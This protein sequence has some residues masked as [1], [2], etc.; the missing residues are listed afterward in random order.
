MQQS[1]KKIFLL[2]GFVSQ[3]NWTSHVP[4][5]TEVFDHQ[6]FQTGPFILMV[7]L[8]TQAKNKG[9]LM[10]KTPVEQTIENQQ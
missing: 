8:D 1:P 4:R 10:F 6:T 3:D 2:Q 5:T 9:P 7:L